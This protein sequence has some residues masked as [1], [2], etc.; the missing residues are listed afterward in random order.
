MADG[1]SRGSTRG[2]AGD[3]PVASGSS[4]F[5]RPNI[6]TEERRGAFWDGMGELPANDLLKNRQAWGHGAGAARLRLAALCCPRLWLEEGGVL[7]V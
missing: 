5:A 3:L 2:L 1:Q 6:W 7:S 4:R